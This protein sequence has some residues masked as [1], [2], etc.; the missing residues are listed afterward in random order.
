MA[1]GIFLLP[2]GAFGG[3]AINS[4]DHGVLQAEYAIKVLDGVPPGSIPIFRG[5]ITTPY[6][7]YQAV[8]KF[9]LKI[10]NLPDGTVLFN[11][12]DT[13]YFNNPQMFRVILIVI[14]V[15]TFMVSF[16]TFNTFRKKQIET[17]LRKTLKEKQILLQEI[18]HRVKNNLQT[19]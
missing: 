19:I 14:V 16:L 15:L 6:F 12:P 9:G 3:I 17:A 18:H 11:T 4:Y 2:G 1:P 5:E 13:L 8:K 7:N 10:S